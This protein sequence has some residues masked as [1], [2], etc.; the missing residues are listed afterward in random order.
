MVH[1]LNPYIYAS[2]PPPSGPLIVEGFDGSGST[3]PGWTNTTF[4][5]TF[6][7]VSGIARMNSGFPAIWTCDT[8]L[9]TNRHYAQMA[10]NFAPGGSDSAGEPDIVICSNRSW[11]YPNFNGYMIRV[12]LLGDVYLYRNGT[13]VGANTNTNYTTGWHTIR[14]AHDGAGGVEV[15]GDGVSIITYTDG[16][17][18]TSLYAGFGW[19]YTNGTN[20]YGDDFEAGDIP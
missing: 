13:Q 8:P 14:V 18:L 3:L 5:G 9:L 11:S 20:S 1:L 2:A 7:R 17:P 19:S 12:D 6:A 16:S 15:F 10:F 4:N